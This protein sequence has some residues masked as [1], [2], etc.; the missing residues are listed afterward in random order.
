M[1]KF[2]SSLLVVALTF[3]CC[4]PCLVYGADDLENIAMAQ[5]SQ[6]KEI[7]KLK[8]RTLKQLEEIYQN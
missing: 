8:K 1:K 7:K 4:E 3:G 5:F 2:L 6:E